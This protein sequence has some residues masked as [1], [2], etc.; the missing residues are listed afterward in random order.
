ME[1]Y[2]QEIKIIELNYLT[3]INT[4]FEFKMS[5]P[6]F[7]SLEQQERIKLNMYLLWL[8]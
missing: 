1:N 7:Y 6:S 8:S 2:D 4:D 3:R 5:L